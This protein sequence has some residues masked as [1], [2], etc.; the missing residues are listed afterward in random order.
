MHCHYVLLLETTSWRNS[1]SNLLF[2]LT[3]YMN[4][5]QQW[6][7]V[8]FCINNNNNDILSL[9]LCLMYHYWLLL[10]W[11]TQTENMMDCMGLGEGVWRPFYGGSIRLWCIFIPANRTLCTNYKYST[12]RYC[13]LHSVIICFITQHLR[14]MTL[15]NEMNMHRLH[16]CEFIWL[17]R[18]MVVLMFQL[19]I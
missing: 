5:G 17:F 13:L 14:I 18:A 12:K 19:G 4:Y 7:Y 9:K 15:H 1:Y 16:Q 10:L 6:I 8:W 3:N 11:T 2:S